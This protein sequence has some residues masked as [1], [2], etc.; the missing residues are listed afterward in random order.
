MLTDLNLLFDA[1]TQED[2]E[3]QFDREM[4]KLNTY[5]ENYKYYPFKLPN[6]IRYMIPPGDPRPWAIHQRGRCRTALQYAIKAGTDDRIFGIPLLKTLDEAAVYQVPGEFFEDLVSA[7]LE[8]ARGKLDL[9]RNG[10]GS[11]AEILQELA[12]ALGFPVYLDTAG[13]VTVLMHDP[14]SGFAAKYEPQ[15]CALEELPFPAILLVPRAVDIDLGHLVPASRWIARSR[16]SG[17]LVV[18]GVLYTTTCTIEICCYPRGPEAVYG[19]VAS[20]RST[21]HP[22]SVALGALGIADSHVRRSFF[23]KCDKVLTSKKEMKRLRKQAK[24]RREPA[25]LPLEYYSMVIPTDTKR[26]IRDL[27]KEVAERSKIR[28]RHLRAGHF[29]M[30]FRRGPLPMSFE[31]REW[32]TKYSYEIYELEHPPQLRR[33][34][35]ELRGHP[36]K[37]N[38]EW[39][40]MKVARVAETVV[41]DESLPMRHAVR[42]IGG[43][44]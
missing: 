32:C 2:N 21:T 17:C 1:P 9:I 8:V 44:K 13:E 6:D 19:Y 33:E 7:P 26:Y 34:Q 3:V 25:P 12:N 36:M 41:G 29:R 28:Y 23:R 14:C 42:K 38:T 39:V 37:E 24:K 16:L 40:A 18:L 43:I 31:D 5:L 30:K 22:D 35:M 11:S 15:G 10:G 27:T 20:V 4:E